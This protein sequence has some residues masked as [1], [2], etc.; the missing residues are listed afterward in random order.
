LTLIDTSAWVEYLRATDSGAHRAVRRLL[1]ADAEVQTTDVVVMEVVAGAR[2]DEHLRQLRRLM[3]RCQY[4][5]VE[6]LDDYE[7]AAALYI[8]CRRAG[9]TVRRLTDCL[10]A[11]VALRSDLAVLHSDRDF[12]LLAIHT[13]LKTFSDEPGRP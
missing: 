10:I 11:A 3:A 7:S 4:I 5:P 1:E 12:D 8:Q 2:D 13:G 6:G 9:S